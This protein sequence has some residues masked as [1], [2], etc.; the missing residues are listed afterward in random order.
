MLDTTQ[1]VITP[2]DEQ[3]IP[4]TDNA[5]VVLMK[6]Y[7]RRGPDGKPNET[8]E[9]M[10]RRV[11][12][13]VAE[14]ERDHGA[15]RNHLALLSAQRGEIILSP[16]AAELIAPQAISPCPLIQP[17][18]ST[19]KN[20]ALVEAALRVYVPGTVMT[21]LTGGLQDWLAVLRPMS[22]LFIGVEGIDY[23][24]P[25]A[26]ATLHEFLRAL[27]ETIYR[28]EGDINML[29]GDLS[30]EKM[31]HRFWTGFCQGGYV[32]HGETYVNEGVVVDG[33]VV[34][35]AGPMYAK[36]FAEAILSL[37]KERL[38]AAPQM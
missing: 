10:F 36:E 9:R 17:D 15:D 1:T 6:R 13:A 14:P 28:Y 29:W 27:Q 35:A 7:V 3:A 34:T 24:R 11:A 38:P 21:W 18:W 2:N 31:M 16:E 30:P 4:L 37:L 5:R 19:V 12:R 25:D 32:G 20:P 26:V 8:V 33:N 23:T 22:V